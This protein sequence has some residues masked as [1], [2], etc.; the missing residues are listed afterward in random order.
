MIGCGPPTH[1]YFTEKLVSD[2][3]QC[4]G[5]CDSC[6]DKLT[7]YQQTK[8]AGICPPNYCPQA[9]SLQRSDCLQSIS[10]LSKSIFCSYWGKD[11]IYLSFGMVSARGRTVSV[12]CKSDFWMKLISLC[13]AGSPLSTLLQDTYRVLHRPLCIHVLYIVFYIII[14]R[15]IMTKCCTISPCIG[16]TEGYGYTMWP[17]CRL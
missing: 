8:L 15:L 6:N 10:I 14:S 9:L 12:R 16:H 2:P 3:F 13:V 11:V 4:G 5:R 7:C 1:R 17:A